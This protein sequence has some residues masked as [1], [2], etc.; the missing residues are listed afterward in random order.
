ME[1]ILT[2]APLISTALFIVYLG[3]V[4][5][6]K[7]IKYKSLKKAII[8]TAN[9]V[10]KMQDVSTNEKI[11]KLREYCKEGIY[12][13]EEIFRSYN[14]KAGAFKLDSLLKDMQVAC[15]KEGI[16]FIRDYWVEYITNE[17][18]KMKG[19]K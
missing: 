14:G 19:V 16:E 12:V 15:M 2:Y 18:K 10:E 4:F 6:L 1:L 7:L 11:L 8:E 3:V 5:A 9:E 13:V 17:V